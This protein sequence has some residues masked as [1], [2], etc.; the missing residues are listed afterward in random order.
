MKTPILTIIALLLLNT[1]PVFAQGR[2]G[3]VAFMDGFVGGLS[4]E[5]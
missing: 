5:Q 3:L 2:A 4:A 1:Q